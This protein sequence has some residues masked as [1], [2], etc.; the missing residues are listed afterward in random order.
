MSSRYNRTLIA[1]HPPYVCTKR[2]PFPRER[3]CCPYQLNAFA[4]IQ[5]DSHKPEMFDFIMGARI[6][7][8]EPGA[9]A[10]GGAFGWGDMWVEVHLIKDMIGLYWDLQLVPYMY[11]KAGRYKMFPNP[12]IYELEIDD[13]WS[14][15]L[16]ITKWDA[17]LPPPKPKACRFRLK[18]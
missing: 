12:I 10:Y 11:D 14:V 13:I 1:P 5:F 18:I 9:C 7:R 6:Y 15:N 2:L 3:E 8:V 4:N 16:N 17:F